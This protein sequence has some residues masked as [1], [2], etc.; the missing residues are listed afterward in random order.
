MPRV[1]APL[2]N[3]KANRVVAALVTEGA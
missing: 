3:A 1:Q 2:K